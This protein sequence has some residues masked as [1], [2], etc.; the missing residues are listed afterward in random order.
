MDRHRQKDLEAGAP[1][2]GILDTRKRSWKAPDGSVVEKRPCPNPPGRGRAY[3]GRARPQ[4]QQVP[5]PEP[6]P[7]DANHSLSSSQDPTSDQHYLG[8]N[9]SP[10]DLRRTTVELRPAHSNTNQPYS[11]GRGGVFNPSETI[12]NF[13][14]FPPSLQFQE[15][16]TTD[17]QFDI[18]ATQPQGWGEQYFACDQ[19]DYDQV[20]QPDTASSFNMPYTTALDYNWLFD[21]QESSVSAT[22]S[23]PANKNQDFETQIGGS[24]SV[25]RTQPNFA[26]TPES[27]K[28]AQL[29]TESM[30][31]T[32]KE[33]RRGENSSGPVNDFQAESQDV[34]RRP[35]THNSRERSTDITAPRRDIEAPPATRKPYTAI[36][37]IAPAEPERPLSSLRKPLTIPSIDDDIRETLLN[38]I[39][40]AKPC[41]PDQRLTIWEH[42]LLTTESLRSYL[43]LFFNRFNTAY[44]LIHLET[45]NCRS[46]EPLLLLSILLLGATYSSKDCHQLAVCIHDVIRPSIFAH[47]GFSPRPE[48]WTL[49]T[50]LLVECFGKS[51]AGQKQHDMSHLFHGLLINLIRR[52]DCQSVRPP[53]PPPVSGEDNADLLEKAWRK[54][55][56]AEQKKRYA[57]VW[58]VPCYWEDDLTY[59]ADSPYYVSCGTPSTQF[60][61]A[62]A[63]V[64]LHLNCVS[65]YPA[66]KVFGKHEMLHPGH[67]L[68]VQLSVTRECSTYQL[69]SHT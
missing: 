49:Q 27:M 31:H 14:G 28:S 12:N 59:N 26:I 9:I 57:C 2:S 54:W 42:P 19:L 65:S 64:C 18:D 20:F 21:I 1:G 43:G 46:T 5:S 6:E 69:S 30:D 3:T 45:F 32:P 51:R 66:A 56:D 34:I 29:W 52:S 67:Q 58:K 15:F 63:F 23:R 25:P 55:A 38:V 24:Q 39:D 10:G 36:G 40:N 53:G 47:A 50:I 48:L 16:I 62:K 68:G 17:N 61:F 7:T 35:V 13:S 33:V 11:L 60:S 4:A 41:L 22:S 44:P 37:G 8:E